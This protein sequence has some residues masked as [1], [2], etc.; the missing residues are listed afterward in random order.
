MPQMGET[1]PGKA[2]TARL[3]GALFCCQEG[4]K[5][6]EDARIAGLDLGHPRP[7]ASSLQLSST[8]LFMVQDVYALCRQVNPNGLQADAYDRA[9]TI[10]KQLV[11]TAK[12]E[13]WA[14]PVLHNK[15]NA[16]P[17]TEPAKAKP[18]P[19]PTFRREL[20]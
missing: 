8:A 17:R 1:A 5:L 14:E 13:I 10:G 18:L 4:R 2:R 3:V 11:E 7:G 19:M 6:L 9:T 12:R 20:V 15:V 16:A